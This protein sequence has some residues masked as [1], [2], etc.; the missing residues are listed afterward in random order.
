MIRGKGKNRM[1]YHQLMLENQQLLAR[2]LLERVAEEG[3]SSGQPKVLEFLLEHDGCMQKDVA[4]HCD[5]EP[6]TTS[7]VLDTLEKNG[8]IVRKTMEGNRRAGS[9]LITEKGREVVEKWVG[10]CHEAEASMLTGFTEEET[11]QFGDF[12]SRAY[13]NMS[14]KEAR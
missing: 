4:E 2:K 11:A 10:H 13:K 7:R 3:L 14:G 1:T 5:I 9:I 6:A 12:L 8:F